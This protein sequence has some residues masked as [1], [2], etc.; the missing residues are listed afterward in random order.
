VTVTLPVPQWQE[1]P[2]RT[3]EEAQKTVLSVLKQ[4]VSHDID[5]IK[6]ARNLAKAVE[7]ADLALHR[8]RL[9]VN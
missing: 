1:L 7:G 3:Q 8:F 2:A 6:Q 4:E 9:Q 5:S